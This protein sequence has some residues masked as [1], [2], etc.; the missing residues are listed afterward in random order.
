MG[1]GFTK[2]LMLNT[3]RY[4]DVELLSVFDMLSSEREPEMRP[5]KRTRV[6]G[7]FQGLGFRVWGCVR[8]GPR[9]CGAPQPPYTTKSRS[10]CYKE[11]Y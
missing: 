5:A 10:T 2:S 3:W 11:L 4:R 6:H 7:P 9:H 8:L 1:F